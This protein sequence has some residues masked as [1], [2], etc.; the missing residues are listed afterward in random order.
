M[1]TTELTMM[2]VATP[3]ANKDYVNQTPAI[4]RG[5]VFIWCSAPVTCFR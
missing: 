1:R 5:F 2:M 4:Q 3:R